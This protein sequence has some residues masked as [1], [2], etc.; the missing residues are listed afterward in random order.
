VHKSP[1]PSP[2]SVHMDD[3]SG[4]G[5]H[6]DSLRAASRS[7]STPRGAGPGPGPRLLSPSPE[8]KEYGK[9]T[10]LE[11]ARCLAETTRK[12]LEA[13]TSQLLE[14]EE[15]VWCV[16]RLYH[17]WKGGGGVLISVYRCEEDLTHDGAAVAPY[18][19]RCGLLFTSGY[20]Q[21]TVWAAAPVAE[22]AAGGLRDYR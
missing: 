5:R 9:L 14:R 19:T 7:G 16:Q 18:H 8:R 20:L 2:R 13:T 10:P 17:P 6:E 1:A 21:M 12:Q 4:V 22:R 15:Q 11:R 3:G